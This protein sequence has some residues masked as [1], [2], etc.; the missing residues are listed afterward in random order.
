MAGVLILIGFAVAG[1]LTGF[2]VIIPYAYSKYVAVAILACLDSVFGALAAN[3]EKKFKIN[4]FLSGFFGN[5]II[6]IFLTYIGQKLDVDIYLAAVIVF[7]GRMLNNF[8]TIRRVLI[9]KFEKR[10]EQKIVETET[11]NNKI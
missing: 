6:A 7:G 5:A 1:V 2:S 10:K 4:V 11:S 8:S 9:N 3:L